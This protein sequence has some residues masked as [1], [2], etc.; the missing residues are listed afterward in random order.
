MPELEPE[1]IVAAYDIGSNAIKMTIAAVSTA[2]DVTELSNDIETVRLGQ[3]VDKSGVLA[4]DRIAAAFAALERMSHAARLAGAGTSIGVA[5][6]AVRVAA[7]GAE[8]LA[9]IRE[10][11]GIDVIRISGQRE[12][13]LTY[14]GLAT[15][16]QLSGPT[17][18]VDIGGA[19][20]E[21][22]VGVGSEV[23]VANSI[24]LGSGRLTDTWIVDDPPSWAEIAAARMAA[25]DQLALLQ[26]ER[27]RDAR[28]IIS[29][30][31]GTY[32]QNFLGTDTQLS[33]PVI[34][35]AL[36]KMKHMRSHELASVIAA[37]PE[38]ARVLPAG[39]A[40]VLA[41][42]DRAA[43]ATIESAPSGMR[44]GLLQAAARGEFS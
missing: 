43:P 10:R 18:M 12:A 26:L 39:V 29:G 44:I 9:T 15:L 33:I 36:A 31:T 32:L 8:F 40:I 34:D 19:S 24:P 28:L 13:A 35:A 11:F 3:D 42:A 4:D 20:T 25:S 37:V 22:V 21:V 7:N 1:T 16:R 27:H 5:T 17:L 14:S 41:I 2:G 23:L 6:E 38:R 30:G